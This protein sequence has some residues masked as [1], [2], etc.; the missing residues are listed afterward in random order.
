MNSRR[1][2]KEIIPN[3]TINAVFPSKIAA[4]MTMN[5]THHALIRAFKLSITGEV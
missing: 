3:K 1:A 5:M 2:N 4:A